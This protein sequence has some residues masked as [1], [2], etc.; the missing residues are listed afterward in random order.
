MPKCSKCGEKRYC[1]TIEDAPPGEDKVCVQC[2]EM[3]E[4]DSG[5][6]PEEIEEMRPK[7]RA[8]CVD[9]PRPCPW[10]SCRYH[11]W[12][13]VE[14]H[15]RV[16]FNCGDMTGPSCVLDEA[17][18]GPKTL[19]EVGEIMGVSKQRA[20]QIERSAS[21]TVASDRELRKAMGDPGF[22]RGKGHIGTRGK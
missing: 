15:G 14:S 10:V 11:L 9:G 20:E 21:I 1:R 2:S 5:F 18:K 16:R 6:T 12:L 3:E 13:N 17:A 7:T 22:R 4:V 8:D 19:T